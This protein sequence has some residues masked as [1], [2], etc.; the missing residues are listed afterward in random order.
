[1]FILAA[2][3]ASYK[4]SNCSEHGECEVT[5]VDAYLA[6]GTFCD[7]SDCEVVWSKTSDAKC[8]CD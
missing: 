8:D 6:F 1:V 4:Q 2:I 5:N 7:N 3:I